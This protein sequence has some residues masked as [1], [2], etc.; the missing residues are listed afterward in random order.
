M[1]KITSMVV[2]LTF[3]LLSP[4]LASAQPLTDINS[5]A[6]KATNIGNPVIALAISFAILW[7]IISV[8]RYLI[9]GAADEDARKK[10]GLAILWGV[11]GLFVILSI[12]GLVAILKN[13]FRTQDTAPIND[14][15][16]TTRL[17]GPEDINM[18]GRYRGDSGLDN[19]PEQYR[20]R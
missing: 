15:Q 18:G 7:I 8:V 6:A 2:I 10:G 14:I 9:A 4:L 13:S 3:S 5:V 16:R 19:V 1:K 17:P 20:W 12:W 11:V